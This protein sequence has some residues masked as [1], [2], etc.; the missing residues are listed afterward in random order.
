MT[1]FII[2]YSTLTRE[3]KTPFFFYSK[4]CPGIGDNGFASKMC[5]MKTWAL[6]SIPGIHIKV[7]E[8]PQS[9]TLM[10]TH[11]LW[12]ACTRPSPSHIHTYNITKI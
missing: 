2:T 5:A 12:H 1:I 3:V 10:S 9:C 4:K 8:T 7:G 11:K 6:N